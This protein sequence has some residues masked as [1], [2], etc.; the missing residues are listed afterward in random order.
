[1]PSAIQVVEWTFVVH[2]GVSYTF[3]ILSM[4]GDSKLHDFPPS[5][6]KKQKFTFSEFLA[7]RPPKPHK[8]SVVR[9]GLI[10]K[11]LT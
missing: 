9:P 1:M 8:S 4:L 11:L 5:Q 3:E 10:Q 6:V 7:P 2:F